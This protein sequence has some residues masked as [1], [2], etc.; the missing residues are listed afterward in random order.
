VS[1][2]ALSGIGLHDGQA[3]YYTFTGQAVNVTCSNSN[4]TIAIGDRLRLH[5]TLPSTVVRDNDASAASAIGVATSTC[6]GSVSG[7]SGVDV[8]LRPKGGAATKAWIPAAACQAATHAASTPTPTLSATPTGTKTPTPPAATIT[9]VLT[10]TPTVTVTPTPQPGGIASTAWSWFA[11][12]APVP[13]CP[14]SGAANYPDGTLNFADGVTTCI[15]T[16]WMLPLD[17]LGTLAVKLRWRGDVGSTGTVVWKVGLQCAADNE[18]ADQ[19]YGSTEIAL[20][21]GGKPTAQRD[22]D[23]TGS[24]AAGAANINSCSAGEDLHIRICR[25]GNDGSDTYKGTA[26]LR[27]MEL[28]VG[29]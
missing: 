7:G 23:V 12:Q 26:M 21:D 29:R 10:A 1:E 9:P 14:S 24:V 6:Q 20:L 25:Y 13:S 5:A 2:E 16:D 19:A 11:D 18:A 27:G 4:G 28:V 3:L 8:L 15:H 22:N 17:W